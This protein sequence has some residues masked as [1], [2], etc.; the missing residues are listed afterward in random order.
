MMGQS[1]RWRRLVKL[2]QPARFSAAIGKRAQSPRAA[3]VCFDCENFLQPNASEAVVSAAR[4]LS[5]RLQE[6]S[7][8]LGINF[9]VYVLFTKVDRIAFFN[10]FVRGMSKAEPLCRCGR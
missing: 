8:Q 1:E 3:V 6:I 4:K 7:R 10:E 9:P 2:L 5:A